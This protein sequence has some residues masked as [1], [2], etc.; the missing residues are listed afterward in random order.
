LEEELMDTRDAVAL[1]AAVMGCWIIVA[2]MILVT[3]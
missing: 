1:W 3:D 2:M